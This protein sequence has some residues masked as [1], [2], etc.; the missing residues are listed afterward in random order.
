MKPDAR[1][2]ATLARVLR[3]PDATV[4]MAALRALAARGWLERAP[5]DARGAIAADPDWMVRL[6]YRRLREFDTDLM[7]LLLVLDDP[8]PAL[9]AFAFTL[10]QKRDEAERI[11]WARLRAGLG[12]ADGA[13][14]LAALEAFQPWKGDLVRSEAEPLLLAA[15]RDANPEARAKAADHLGEFAKGSPAVVEAL[16]AALDDSSY[17]VRWQAVIALQEA[18]PGAAKGLPALTRMLDDE[19]LREWAAE[20]IGATGVRDEEAM[21]KLEAGL[22]AGDPDF[23]FEAARALWR[24]GSPPADFVEIVAETLVGD[25]FRRTDAAETL[26]ELGEQAR[27]YVPDLIAALEDEA[28][29]CDAARALGRLGAMAEAALPAL[30]RLRDSDG[31]WA[32]HVAHEAIERIR[33]DLDRQSR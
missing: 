18:G 12:D 11:P 3:D 2:D 10:L 22:G 26:G 1:S 17:D 15:V 24:L 20:I 31:G 32:Q 30:E 19:W 6:A 9:R 8:H 13:V 25:S 21:R 27:P 14:R 5:A 4:R 33:L 29:Q 7:E 23:R 16:V 28:C